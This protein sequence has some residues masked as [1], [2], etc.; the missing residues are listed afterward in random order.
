M[1]RMK[2]LKIGM[3]LR[4]IGIKKFRPE[5][6]KFF[7]KKYPNKIA[8]ITNLEPQ[9]RKDVVEMDDWFFFL[10]ELEYIDGMGIQLKLF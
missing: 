6:Q 2:D 7:I 3:K 9:G 5:T 8:K 10:D 1:V 4:A